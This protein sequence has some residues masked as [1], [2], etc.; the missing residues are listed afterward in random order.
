MKTAKQALFEAGRIKEIGRGR[1]SNDNH[2]WLLAEVEKG[3]KFTDYPKKG[4]KVEVKPATSTSPEAATYVKPAAAQGNGKVVADLHYRY[5]DEASYYAKPVG[6]TVYG[7]QKFGM[8]EVCACGSSLVACFCDRPVIFG[9]VEV[10]VR[11]K[12]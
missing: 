4:A 5:T 11:L 1:I 9:N 7:I 10:E 3:V 2:I 8:R 6:A 12:T